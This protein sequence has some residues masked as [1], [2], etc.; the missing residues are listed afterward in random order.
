MM[1]C[2]ECN[3]ELVDGYVGYGSGIL[4]H[5]RKLTG[6]RRIFPIALLNGAFILGN[7]TSPGVYTF[8]EARKCPECNTV[9]LPMKN[10]INDYSPILG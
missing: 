9:V 7:W 8:V 3:S 5:E 6:W 1:H 10:N 4:W 2:P